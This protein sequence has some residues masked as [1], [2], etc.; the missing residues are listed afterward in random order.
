MH[1]ACLFAIALVAA[2]AAPLHAQSVDAYD[3]SW[4]R[5]TFWSGEYPG[6]FSVV[7]TTT[8]QLR[9][10]PDATAERSIAC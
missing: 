9:P 5:A 7:Q 2:G 4:H 8:V 10:T 6:G 3:E 1:K